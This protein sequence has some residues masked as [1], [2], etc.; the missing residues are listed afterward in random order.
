MYPRLIFDLSSEAL[1]CLTRASAE[2][3]D[4]ETSGRVRLMTV[5]QA[6]GLEFPVVFVIGAAEGLFPTQRSIDDGD[7][8]EERRLFYVAS[9]RAMDLLV[10]T[11]PRVFVSGGNFETRKA[12]RF[13]EDISPSTYD[14]L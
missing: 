3:R 6:K 13:L 8:D 12:S 9:T 4:S 1:C 10:I 5:H 7:V 14:V 11:Y 2:G